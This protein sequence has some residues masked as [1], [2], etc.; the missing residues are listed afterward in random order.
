VSAERRD[1]AKVLGADVTVDPAME[2]P[3]EAWTQ[4]AASDDPASWAAPTAIFGQLPLRPTV[5]FE[6]T[7]ASGLLQQMIAGAPA[8][9]RLCVAGINLDTDAI[10]PA[11]G[12]FKELDVRFSLYYSPEEFAAY[13]KS[14][15]DKYAKVIRASG[16]RSI[17]VYR[18]FF[19]PGS[20][21]RAIH[22]SNSRYQSLECCGLRIQWFSSG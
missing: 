5:G 18:R 13:I 10:E 6:C 8:G 11:H 19:P 21:H 14:E 2:S 17:R 20:A 7:G 16:R 9:S 15:A 3:Y 22:C 1:L 12:I 4:A